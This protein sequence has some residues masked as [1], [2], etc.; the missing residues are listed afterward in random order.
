[1]T[2]DDVRPRL[3]AYLDGD[4]DPD[5]GTVV[6]GHLRSCDA[7]RKVAEHE[8]VLRDG[9]RDLPT[10][11]APSGMWAN[12]QAQLA[13][14]E[15]AESKRPAWKR[16][17]A[18]W[19]PMVPRF[20]MGGVLAAAAVGILWWRTHESAPETKLV[21]APSPTIKSSAPPIAVAPPTPGCNLEAPN[22]T[23]V[24]ADL[25]SEAARVT[26]CYAQTA[27]EL[28]ALAKE[29]RW[30]EAQR[31]SF[32]AQVADLQKAVDTAEPGRPQQRAYRAL[33]RYVQ[34]TLTRDTVAFAS[35]TP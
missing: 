28:L 7:C 11:D 9:L 26:G 10:V 6:R 1:M 23:D 35:T 25:A 4:L 2:C 8:A 13:A 33:N 15:V 32:D 14:A 18:R 30:T 12:I 19:T 5:R 20:A 16:A 22:D 34:N 31:A 27:S 17:L 3:T 24:T 21:D 29:A